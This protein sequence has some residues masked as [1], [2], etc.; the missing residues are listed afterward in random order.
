ML[1]KDSNRKALIAPL[2]LL[3]GS[4]GKRPVPSTADAQPTADRRD[5]ATS[6]AYVGCTAR[7]GFPHPDANP[8]GCNDLYLASLCASMATNAAATV[9]IA[10]RAWYATSRGS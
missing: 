3:A 10:W 7:N 6:V 8:P 4:L 1:W 5:T 2:V 9:L